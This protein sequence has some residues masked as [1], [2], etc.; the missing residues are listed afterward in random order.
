MKYPQRTLTKKKLNP[1]NVLA[2]VAKKFKK[3]KIKKLLYYKG[4]KKNGLPHGYGK[5]LY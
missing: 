4:E 1:L 5:L 2:S 3:K